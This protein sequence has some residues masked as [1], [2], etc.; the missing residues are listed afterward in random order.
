MPVVSVSMPEDLL[1]RLDTVATEHDYTGR[2][3]VVREGVR[4]LLGE[5]ETDRLEHR[6]LAC[7]VSV[8]YDFGCQSV[9]RRITRLRHEHE[10][11]IASNVHSHVDEYCMELFVLEGELDDVSTFV[12]RVRSTEDVRAVEYSLVPLDTVGQLSES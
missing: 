10:S 1:E 6:P 8:L 11:H 3:E 2:S 9:E 5:F 4:T 7:V 12:G